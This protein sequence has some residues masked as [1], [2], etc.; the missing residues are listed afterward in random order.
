MDDTE[1]YTPTEMGNLA[2]NHFQSIL[3]PSLLHLGLSPL[4]SVVNYT[5]SVCP[6]E[7]VSLMAKVPNAE[8]ITKAMFKLNP[9]KS[10]RPNG[11]TSG[12][13][14]S[15]WSVLGDEVINSV[16]RFFNN[17]F[18]PRA[19]NY[20]IF[21]LV[22]KFPGASIIKDHRP[23][24][25]CNT[26]Y[27]VISKLLV[28]K[29]KP[30]LPKIILPNQTVFIK[31]RQLLENC[32]LASE[33]VS[34]YHKN[35]GPKRIIMKIDIAKAFDTVRWDFILNCLKALQLSDIYITWVASCLTT[36]SYSVGINGN[37]HGYF[38]G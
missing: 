23:I 1:V 38:T 34:G 4:P 22:P 7:A 37:L 14:K 16:I 5:G 32:L 29:L 13:Y 36:T 35:K 21:T 20:T 30:L 2:S 12:F 24:S 26:I 19:T 6:L 27:K 10:P 3:G 18:M 25:C 28:A 8:E 11:F 17:P 33:I 31:G 9:N 15:S